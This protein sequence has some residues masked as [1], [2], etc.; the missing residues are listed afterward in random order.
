MKRALRQSK[1]KNRR[2]YTSLGNFF[3]SKRHPQKMPLNPYEDCDYD[4]IP[5]ITKKRKNL[6]FGNF[7]DRLVTFLSH[8]ESGVFDTTWQAKIECD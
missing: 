3:F 2:S 5:K 7:S 4:L 1:P 6:P 8:I